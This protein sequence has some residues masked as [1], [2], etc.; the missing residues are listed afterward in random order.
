MAE[1]LKLHIKLA[2]STR[3]CCRVWTS[4]TAHLGREVKGKA[5]VFIWVW[6]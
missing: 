3:I 5:Q 1:N 6:V 4:A 2:Q